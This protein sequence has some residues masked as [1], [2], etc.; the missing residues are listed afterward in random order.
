[1]SRLRE[2]NIDDGLLDIPLNFI[3]T[4]HLANVDKLVRRQQ[5]LTKGLPTNFQS[6]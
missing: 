4:L 3:V 6:R 5:Y 1:M 2:K